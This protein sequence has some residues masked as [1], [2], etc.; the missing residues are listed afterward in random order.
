MVRPV[1]PV[2]SFWMR[3]WGIEEPFPVEE[4]LEVQVAFVGGLPRENEV[5]GFFDGDEGDA[6]WRRQRFGFGSSH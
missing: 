5:L 2:C 4:W 3:L 6:F 1:D